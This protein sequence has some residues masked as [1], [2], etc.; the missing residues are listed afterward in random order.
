M[1]LKASY[2]IQAYYYKIFILIIKTF[3]DWHLIKSVKPVCKITEVKAQKS[4]GNQSR[5]WPFHRTQDPLTPNPLRWLL[6]LISR[7]DV[8]SLP[9]SRDAP[10]NETNRRYFKFKRHKIYKRSK[11]S[12][13]FYFCYIVHFPQPLLTYEFRKLWSR[14]R[15]RLNLKRAFFDSNIR[16]LDVRQH[17]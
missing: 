6:L 16:S 17:Q 8:T 9:A 15:R 7:E 14:R 2:F 4:G 12:I 10:C 1:P 3:P 5:F 13:Y 11:I